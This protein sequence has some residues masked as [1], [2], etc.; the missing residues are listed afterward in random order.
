MRPS[1]TN[2]SRCRDEDDYTFT[3]LNF[4]YFILSLFLTLTLSHFHS[5][6]LSLFILWWYSDFMQAN[7]A[8]II[9]SLWWGS[10]SFFHIFTLSHFHNFTLSTIYSFTLSLRNATTIDKPTLSSWGWWSSFNFFTF[11]PNSPQRWYL[12]LAWVAALV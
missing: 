5:F 4:H 2:P 8:I 1:F 12:S 9:S 7:N 6:T 10:W 3:L 11:S